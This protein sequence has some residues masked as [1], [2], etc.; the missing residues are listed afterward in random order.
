MAAID[1]L[2]QS[3]DFGLAERLSAPGRR[4]AMAG[5]LSNQKAPLGE[6]FDDDRP[7]MAALERRGGRSQIEAGHRLP[8][9]IAPD[10]SR[11]ERGQDFLFKTRALLDSLLA[12]GTGHLIRRRPG[13]DPALERFDVR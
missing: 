5:D 6:S 12:A 11:R 2:A 10:A 9:S 4:H 13:R 8:R 1:P 7:A 3:A